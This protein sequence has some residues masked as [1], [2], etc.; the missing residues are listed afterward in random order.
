MPIPDHAKWRFLLST[1]GHTA[2][3]RLAELMSTDSVV[4]KQES[5][6]IEY[7]YRWA[8]NSQLHIVDIG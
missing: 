6:W 8:Y 2:S 4:M 5:N 1:D 3:C 7:Y